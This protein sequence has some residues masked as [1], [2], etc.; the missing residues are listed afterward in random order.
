MKKELLVTIDALAAPLFILGISLSGIG[1]L[2]RCWFGWHGTGLTYTMLSMLSYAAV[3]A[4][5]LGIAFMVISNYA[6]H[7][8]TS[9]EGRTMRK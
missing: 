8:G 6:F 1:L 4:C 7:G 9:A 2:L 3:G 5:A